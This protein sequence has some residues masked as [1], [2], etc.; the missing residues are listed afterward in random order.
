MKEEVNHLDMRNALE[1]LCSQCAPSGF[2]RP[3][4]E[5]AAELLRPF[6]DEVSIDRMGNVVGVRRC[7]ETFGQLYSVLLALPFCFGMPEPLPG[8]VSI[9]V[10]VAF[11][12]HSNP[13]FCSA[14]AAAC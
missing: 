5:V 4:A 12:L 11:L 2:E 1:R 3:A 9:A 13:V 14:I 6:V 8:T 10:S 7:F